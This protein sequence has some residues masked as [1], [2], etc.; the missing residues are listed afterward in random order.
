MSFGNDIADEETLYWQN[1]QDKLCAGYERKIKIYQIIIILTINSIKE[2]IEKMGIHSE[3]AAMAV[4]E[5]LEKIL[6]TAIK[7]DEPSI[8]KFCKEHL[9]EWYLMEISETYNAMKE[10]EAI[11]KYFS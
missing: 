3:G 6:L 8:I 10:N 11:V 5:Q 2:I 7:A 4:A 1:A 9:Y